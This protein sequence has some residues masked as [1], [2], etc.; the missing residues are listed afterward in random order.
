[1]LASGWT[2][3][4]FLLQ[5]SLAV[6]ATGFA[7]GSEP[8]ASL[9]TPS[10]R[11]RGE[12]AEG[13]R[14][15]RGIPFARPPIGPLRFRPPE[16]FVW[17]GE[18]DATRFAP[19]AMQSSRGMSMSE[20]CLALNVWTPQGRGPFPVFVWIHGG[21]FLGGRS[22]EPVLDG[23]EMAR[24]GVVCITV[25]YRLG[26]FGF[27]DMEPLLGPS[28]AGSANLALH[29]LIAAL[30]WVHENVEA[31]GGDPEHVTV[32]G[33]SAGAKLTG[34]LMSIAEA[35]PYFHQ[36]ISQSG[37]AERVGTREHS[38]R[39]AEGFAEELKNAG[40]KNVREA[41]AEE[42]IALQHKFLTRWPEHFPLRAEID[43]H[44]IP[45]LPTESIAAGSARGKRLL[46]GTM[47]DESALF[48]GAHPKHEV[49]AGDL[50]NLALPRFTDVA[51]RYHDV[52]PQMG[53]EELRIRALTAEEYWIPSMGMAAAHLQGGGACWLYRVDFSESSGAYAGR[54][55]HGLDV[56]LV[57]NRPSAIAANAVEEAALA[58]Q[59]NQAWIRY[60]RGEAPAAQGLPEW[61]RMERTVRYTMLLDHV[62]RVEKNPQEA[63]LRLWNGA[64]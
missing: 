45:R 42:L 41:P 53:A 29:D 57:W 33:E 12:L 11:L 18:H 64:L 61:P 25:A 1:M 14:V 16:K 40:V 10:G 30:R 22:S 9:T 28:Y 15:F 43:G 48:I 47:R 56:R 7:R 21:G 27:L 31:F 17:S 50:G 5:A 59:M 38:Q 62:S 58:R 32:G 35:R 49:V 19:A 55:E 3:R 44:L 54:A 63:E 8:A 4:E 34:I 52:Y 36:M 6:L 60:I 51:K 20:D 37:G 13:V 2:R 26:V 23:A 39:V 46:L 24:A